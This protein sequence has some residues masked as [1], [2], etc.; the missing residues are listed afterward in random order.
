MDIARVNFSVCAG[1]V[2]CGVSVS[3]DGWDV[4]VPAGAFVQEPSESVQGHNVFCTCQS[5]PWASLQSMPI[6]DMCAILPH[7]VGEG[8]NS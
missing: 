1:E 7:E 5:T 6:D 2:W 4:I 8:G 3:E